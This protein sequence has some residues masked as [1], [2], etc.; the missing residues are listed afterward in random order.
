MTGQVPGRPPV[1]VSAAILL[2]GLG[3]FQAACTALAPEMAVRPVRRYLRRLDDD[4]VRAAAVVLAVEG[5]WGLPPLPARDR[6]GPLSDVERDARI[7]QVQAWCGR[8]RLEAQWLL[9]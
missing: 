9:G 6:V 7:R 8:R 3:A 4:Q 1:G 5:V 2:D